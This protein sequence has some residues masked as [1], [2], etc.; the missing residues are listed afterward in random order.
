[1]TLLIHELKIN[2]KTLLIWAC[3]VGIIC[4]GCILLFEGLAET[5]EGMS[6]MY[7]NMG[8]FSAALGLD[9]LS[10]STMEGYYATEVALIF[11]IGGAMFA[12]M[13]GAAMISKEEEGHTGEF[14]NTLPFGRSYIVLWKYAALVCLVLL[15]NFLC[16]LWILVGFWG[17][18]EMPEVNEF[19]MYHGMQVLM[20]LE[21]GSICFFISALSK[22]KQ[23]GAALGLAILLYGADMMCRVVPDIENLK[24]VTPYYFSNG[25]DIFASGSVDGIMIIISI[26]ITI[27]AVLAATVIYRRR[28]LS[29]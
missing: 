16:L 18:G 10:I 11:A 24:Y 27:A 9:K 26:L 3:S 21:V 25:A 29:A 22:R 6:D 14:L 8:A 2:V 23:T 15:F 17:A 12:A 7:A 20:H 4:F 13:T 5:M 28:D 19:I 1:M